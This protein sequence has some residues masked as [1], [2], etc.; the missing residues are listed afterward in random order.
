MARK[1]KKL[2]NELKASG[3][4]PGYMAD[5]RLRQ[6][7]QFFQEFSEALNVGTDGR[8]IRP[9]GV[10]RLQESEQRSTPEFSIGD[11]AND[12][13]IRD[14]FENLVVNKSDGEP[15]GSS[16]V[17][18]FCNPGRNGN[19]SEAMSAV[20]STA[21]LGITGQLMVTKI[22]EAYNGEEYQFRKAI[23]THNT[24]LMQEKFIG[25][26]PPKDPG[27]NDLRT[28]E[29][30]E[31]KTFGFGEQYVQT[32]LTLKEGA[33]I[34]LT[35]EAIFFNL[36]GDI[37]K[38]ASDVGDMLAF[39]E[40][41]ECIGA[42]IGNYVD[43]VFF[44][45]KRQFDSA[46]VTLDM[47]QAAAS[48][49]ANY[50][51]QLYSQNATRPFAFVND[52]P[53]NPLTDF[54]AIVTCD[55]YFTNIVSPNT[56]RPI[57][58]G[59]PMVIAPHTQRIKL[60]R[61]VQAESIYATT[62]AGITAAGGVMTMSPNV[63]NRIGLQVSDLMTSRLLKAELVSTLGVTAAQADQ[64]WL[65]GDLGKAFIYC[66]NWPVEVVQAPTNSEPEFTQDIVL[67]WK[68]SRRGRIA[69][70]EARQMLRNNFLSETSST[71]PAD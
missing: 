1:A 45:E 17:D 22:L 61:V 66:Q 59:K 32:P 29:G 43:P 33:I 56:G 37:T 71:L 58:V 13:T 9:D 64:I 55:Q 41:Q 4:R 12:Y 39:S 36:T 52:V 67:R 10:Q 57:V 48:Q 49:N 63:L 53:S 18:M 69:I 26:T 62:Q 40:E 54:E 11:G 15:V 23:P 5:T 20:D 42:L 25:T 28:Q 27:K 21:F 31:Y 34:G 51:H 24:P 70:L 35:K 50:S 30:E 65:Y 68:A 47:Y 7:N 8:G 46:P 19:L 3:Y 2:W 38:R 6:E 44:V 60:M 16:F 14:L